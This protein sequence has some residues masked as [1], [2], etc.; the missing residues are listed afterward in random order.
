MKNR[1]AKLTTVAVVIVGISIVISYVGQG[2]QG[3]ALGDVVKAMQKVKTVTWT[4]SA[5]VSPPDDENTIQ[6]SSGHI[7]RCAYKAPSHERREVTQNL[8]HPETKQI[9]EHKH[10]E[11][12][13]RNAGNVLSLNPQKMTAALYSFEPVS[14]EDPIFDVFLNPKRNIPPNAESLGSKQIGDRETVGF[15]MHKMADGTYFWA[16]EATDIWVDTKTKRVV[17][18]E[19]TGANGRVVYR[20]KDFVFDQELDD[21]LFS[22][23]LPEGYKQIAPPPILSIS[24]EEE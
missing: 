2:Q 15:R 8:I 23:K 13:D 16:G 12:I 22:L 9:Y 6:V 24:P 14:G 20:L 7:C 11:I 1:I 17:L 21:S 3:I 4:E 10:V 19:T 5:E 18:V